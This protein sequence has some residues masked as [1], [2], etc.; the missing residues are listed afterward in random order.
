MAELLVLS[1]A[2]VERLLDLDAMLEALEKGFRAISD[3]SVSTPPRIASVAPTGLLAAMPAWV[4]GT[5]ETKLVSVF[6]GN[7]ERGLPSHQAVIAL[8][9]ES[10]GTPLALLDGTHITAVRTAGGS[11][12]ATRLLARPGA[13]T[14]AIL[15][16]GVQAA[17]HLRLLGAGREVRIAGRRRGSAEALA[18]ESPGAA[19]AGSFEEAVRGADIVCCCTDGMDPVIQAGWV[20]PGAHVNSVGG[21]PRGRGELPA[22]LV[23]AAS[24]FVESPITFEPP[25]AGAAELAGVDRAHGSQLGEVLAG[26]KPGRTSEAQITVYKSVGHA[27]EDACAARLVYD[28]ALAEGA[29]V[30]VTI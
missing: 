11:A 23:R 21:S 6:P 30:R 10:T 1:R 26:R 16:T 18:A 4:P 3:S 19:V 5:L 12:V 20:S 7:G 9:D 17:W 13:R 25:P 22:D 29:G 24:L 8:F 14:L 27:V 2:E 15:G 28:R